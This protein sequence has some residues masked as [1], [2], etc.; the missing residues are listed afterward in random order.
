VAVPRQVKQAADQAEQQLQEMY[1]VKPEPIQDLNADPVAELQPAAADTQFQAAPAAD[2]HPEPEQAA[3]E[4]APDDSGWEQKYKT[5]QGMYNKEVPV[6]RRQLSQ[7]EADMEAMRRLLAQMHANQVS[8]PPQPSQPTPAAAKRRVTEADVTD[9]GEDLI[10][11]VQRASLDALDPYVSKL[12]AKLAQFENMMG[13][14]AQQTQLSA[15]QQLFDKLGQAVP[16]WEDIN[17]SGEFIGWLDEADPY[18]GV[19]R[20]DLLT[21]AFERND[22]ARVIAFFKG[23]LRDTGAASEPEQRTPTP[24]AGRADLR[25]MVSPG[26]TRSSTTTPSKSNERIWSQRDIAS[27]YSDVLQGKYRDNVAKKEQ[28]EREIIAAVNEGR[29]RN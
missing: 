22:V 24:A 28:I 6:L 13:G 11:V 12:E 21:Q 16:Q 5:L 29:V 2:E 1:K 3:A 8:T 23:F 20:Q 26:K 19:R 27:F 4:P 10:D 25:T 15:R 18:V 7:M 17:R 14:V 9:Y